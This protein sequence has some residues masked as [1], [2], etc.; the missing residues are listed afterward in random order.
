MQNEPAQVSTVEHAKHV[1]P[2]VP[3]L[4]WLG[5]AL[6]L[7]VEPPSQ[8]PPEHDTESQTQAWLTQRFPALQAAPV[9]QLQAPA[10]QRSATVE[11]H[12]VHEPPPVPHRESVGGAVQLPL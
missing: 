3:H 10:V 6:Q 4:S 2:P 7:P 8:Q 11:L 1:V 5:E 9:P 12:G